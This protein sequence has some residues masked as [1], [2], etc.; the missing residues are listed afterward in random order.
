MGIYQ[1]WVEKYRPRKITDVAHQEEVVHTL[2]HSLSSGHLPHVLMY[3][4][5][6]TGKTTSALAMVR[7]LFGPELMKNRVL[8]LNAS[9]ERG[10][11]VVRNKIKDF[12]ATAVGDMQTGILVLRTR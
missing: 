8:E 4:P 3:G 10:I 12:A 5:P 11:G 6:G 9:D 7:Q 2:S 1:P